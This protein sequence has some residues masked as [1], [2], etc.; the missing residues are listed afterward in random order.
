MKQLFLIMMMLVLACSPTSQKSKKSNPTEEASGETS[1]KSEK[2]EKSS[3]KAPAA[4]DLASRLEIQGS[5]IVYDV[6]QKSL[7]ETDLSSKVWAAKTKKEKGKKAASVILDKVWSTGNSTT[8]KIYVRQIWSELQ[9]GNLGLKLE[10]YEN[11]EKESSGEAKLTHLLKTDD[12]V[13]KDFVSVSIPAVSAKDGMKVLI[14]LSPGLREKEK[15]IKPEDFPI[16]LKD[17]VISEKPDVLW[18]EDVDAIGKYVQIKT[19][20][21][22]LLLS[23]NEFK[24]SQKMGSAMESK[25]ELKGEVPNEVVITSAEALLPKRVKFAVYGMYLPKNKTKS[26]ASFRVE[27]SNDEEKFLKK[28]E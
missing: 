26:A 21:G 25:M 12:V 15:T 9:D 2:T 20:R 22:T 23:Y 5:L 1:E 16:I 8:G 6:N 19:H 13:I 27:D 28:I 14:K 18:A 17:A 24:G 10:Q 11:A 3:D 7:V 4:I